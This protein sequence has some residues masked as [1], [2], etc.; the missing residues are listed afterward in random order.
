MEKAEQILECLRN[1]PDILRNSDITSDDL[2]I[3]HIAVLNCIFKRECQLKDQF[4]QS[5]NPKPR[6][7]RKHGRKSQ[8][9]CRKNRLAKRQKLI[10]QARINSPYPHPHLDW[11]ETHIRTKGYDIHDLNSYSFNDILQLED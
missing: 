6:Y 7:R 8:K 2:N 3:A 11:R 1:H 4:K 10:M 9:K 5:L